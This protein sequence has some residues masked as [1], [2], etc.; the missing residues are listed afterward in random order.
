MGILKKSQ[1]LC[2]M[3]GGET[4]AAQTADGAGG[5]RTL[6]ELHP[7]CGFTLKP[8]WTWF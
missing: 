4:L 2:E 1:I 6:A 7:S 8:G 3:V 5:E